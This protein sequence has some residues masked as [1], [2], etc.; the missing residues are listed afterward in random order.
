MSKVI[1]TDVGFAFQRSV[2]GPE[3][4][5]HSLNQSDAKQEPITT[6][7]P[8]FF[9]RFQI[10][11]LIKQFFGNQRQLQEIISHQISLFGVIQLFGSIKKKKFHFFI[12]MRPSF[13]EKPRENE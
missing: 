1:Q 8:A 2:I 6:W 5:L 10:N 9:L 11:K 12:R 13:R 4:S 7:S 3:K